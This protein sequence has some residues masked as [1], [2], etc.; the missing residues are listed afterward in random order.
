M[1]SYLWNWSVSSTSA[2]AAGP[3]LTLPT[4]LESDNLFDEVELLTQLKTRMTDTQIENFL[5]AVKKQQS[6][7]LWD[8]MVDLFGYKQGNQITNHFMDSWWR[9]SDDQIHSKLFQLTL[10]DMPTSIYDKKWDDMLHFLHRIYGY[11]NLQHY[12]DLLT[13]HWFPDTIRSLKNGSL[14]VQDFAS[15][16]VEQREIVTQALFYYLRVEELEELF[17]FSAV[18]PRDEVITPI[19][20]GNIQTGTVDIPPVVEVIPEPELPVEPIVPVEPTEPVV[21]VEPKVRAFPNE[22][23]I[24]LRTQFVSFLITGI[25][26]GWNALTNW[27]SG[28]WSSVGSTGQG[29][30]ASMLAAFQNLGTNLADLAGW[31]WDSVVMS[32]QWIA[33]LIRDGL[34]ALFS[35]LGAFFASLR[36]G[37]IGLLG[38]F[39][40]A[41]DNFLT[42]LFTG[43]KNFLSDLR[44]SLT[45]ALHNGLAGLWN[46]LVNLFTGLFDAIVSLLYGIWDR[47]INLLAGLWSS[48]TN[49]FS[50]FWN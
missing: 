19:I 49:F 16:P 36:D 32:I 29:I 27:T 37:L 7:T 35:G 30:G 13:Q 39:G 47:I 1:G 5:D 42:G 2:F 43:L 41:L 26:D 40:V 15:L 44:A 4:P 10:D 31:I 38:N 8:T 34:T 23:E 20:T 21:P 11:E 45:S 9:I 12:Q 22:K 48:L 14:S 3:S 28:L 46:W 25:S 24:S 50:S 6:P 18:V 33:N 17:T